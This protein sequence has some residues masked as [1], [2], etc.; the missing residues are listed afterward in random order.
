MVALEP[1]VLVQDGKHRCLLC[2][3][4]GGY[5]LNVAQLLGL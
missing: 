2:A 1:P 4:L 5:I 3:A